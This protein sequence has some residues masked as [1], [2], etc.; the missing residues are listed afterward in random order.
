MSKISNKTFLSK[1]KRSRKDV[2]STL[3]NISIYV[4]EAIRDILEGVKENTEFINEEEVEET[5][6]ENRG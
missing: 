5:L 2:R 6:K 4:K 3:A 1:V